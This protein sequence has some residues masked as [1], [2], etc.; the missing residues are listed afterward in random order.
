MK[1][2]TNKQFISV[3]SLVPRLCVEVIIL[4]KD[5]IV[6]TKRNIE[7]AKG[8]WHLPGGTVLKGERLKKAVQRIARQETGLNVKVDKLL[9]IIEYSF[10]NYFAS[11]VG[12][13]FQTS[14]KSGQQKH[15]RNADEIATFKKLPAKMIVAQ[16]SFIKNHL[17]FI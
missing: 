3:Y 14:V 7:P 10:K 1:Q 17:D 4:T 15:D 6:L 8:Y 5:G 11:A 16:K 13:A 2:L 12:V 9:G